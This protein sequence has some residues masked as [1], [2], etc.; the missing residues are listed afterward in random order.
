MTILRKGV[1]MRQLPQLLHRFKELGQQDGLTR[2]TSITQRRL[3]TRLDGDDVEVP[4]VDVEAQVMEKSE[5][6]ATNR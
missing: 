1:H 6:E 5:V 3:V 4:I 2:F